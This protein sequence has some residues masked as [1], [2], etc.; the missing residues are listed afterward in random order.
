MTGDTEAMA[1]SVPEGGEPR[2]QAAAARPR[3]GLRT[4]RGL[5]GALAGGLVVLAAAL[6]VAQWLVTSSGRPGPGLAVVIGHAVAAIAAVLVQAVA[7]RSRGS[8]AWLASTTV[9]VIVAV[10]LWFG[11]WA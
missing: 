7:D 9:L 5:T 8:R 1:P 6:G 11:W 3:L 2:P 10:T 4:L